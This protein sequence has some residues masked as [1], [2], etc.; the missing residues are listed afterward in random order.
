MFKIHKLNNININK[1]NNHINEYIEEINIFVRQM[2]TRN[3]QKY[4][5]SFINKEIQIKI[6]MNTTSQ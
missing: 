2:A 4:L 5:S 3:M 1:I 6:T